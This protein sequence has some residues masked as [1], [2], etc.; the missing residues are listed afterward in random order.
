MTHYIFF[1]KDTLQADGKG[2]KTSSWGC[3]LGINNQFLSMLE[4]MVGPK[5]HG[6]S[7]LLLVINHC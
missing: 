5:H 1:P 7:D 4:G 3:F 2:I 6:A